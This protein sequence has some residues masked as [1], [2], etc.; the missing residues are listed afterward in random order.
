MNI[1]LVDADGGNVRK[2]TDDL[3]YK[4]SPHWSPDEK[5]ITYHARRGT[6]PE[7]SSQVYLIQADSPGRPKPMGRGSMPPMVQ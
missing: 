5:W 3:L 1:Y 7:D 6:E 2:L 4:S